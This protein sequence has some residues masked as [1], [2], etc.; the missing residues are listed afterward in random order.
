MDII[1]LG[2]GHEFAIPSSFDLN[3]LRQLTSVKVVNGKYIPNP[4]NDKTI[5]I[6]INQKVVEQAEEVEKVIVEDLKRERDQYNRW[7]SDARTEHNKVKEEL[8][9]L[10]KTLKV[11][12]EEE[13]AS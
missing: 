6:V 2:Y 11:V 8:T 4:N 10:K 5:E 1:K 7:W 13:E 12:K 3:Q 9:C